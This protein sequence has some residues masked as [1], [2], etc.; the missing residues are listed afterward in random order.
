MRPR[1]FPLIALVAFAFTGCVHAPQVVAPAFTLPW[2]S[3]GEGVTA[4]VDR[5]A[6]RSEF[7]AFRNSS[8][9]GR[10]L[11]SFAEIERISR[12]NSREFSALEREQ[13]RAW[14]HSS[15]SVWFYSFETQLSGILFCDASGR[16]QHAILLG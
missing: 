13:H 14:F 15:D 16:V 4:L 2:Q 5:K 11:Q 6:H 10:Q 1:T 9:P 8:D 12:G 3:V 7:D